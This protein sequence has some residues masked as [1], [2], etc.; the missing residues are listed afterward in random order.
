MP[1]A[2]CSNLQCEYSIEL[3]D[4]ET[5]RS[6]E[7][8]V[9]CPQCGS[10]IISICPECGFLLL[11]RLGAPHCVVCLA[12]VRLAFAKRHACARFV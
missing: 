6:T 8:P 7:T 4:R 2:L 11:D 10:L 9:A 3:H 1:Y 5:G 12:D